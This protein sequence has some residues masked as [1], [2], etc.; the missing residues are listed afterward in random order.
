M[1]TVRMTTAQALVKFLNQQYVEFDGEQQK[2]I[3]GIFT[4]FGHGNVV[5]LGQALEEDAGELE[6]YQGRN[7]Q[8]MA[9]A[10]MAFAKQKHRKQIMACTS[11]VGP[12]SANMITSAATASANNI[13]VLLLPGDVFA[14]RQ[15]DPVLQQIEQTHD[16]SISTN[17][18][19]RAV[20]KYWDRVNRPEQLM[21]AMIQAIRVLTNPADTGAVTICLP[22]DVQGE[23]WDFPSYFFQK[24]VHR[25]ERRLPTKASLADAV[26]MIKKKKK[27]I[28]ICGGGV[29]YA[30]AA[31]ELKQFAETFR[32]P[33]GETQAGKSTIESNHPYNLGGIGVTGN[34]A[35]N[36][37]AKEAD[38]VIGIG[39]RFTD[40]TTASK[41]LFQNKEVEFLNI[42]ISE[43]HA[44]KLDA[45]KVIA[46]AKEALLALIDELQ[47]IEYQSSYTVEIADAKE[48][49]ETELARLHNI[50]FTSQD[51]KPEVEGHF[52]EDLNEY[53]DALGT[54]LT[55]TTV[56]GQINTLIDEDAIIVGAAGSLPG[57]LQRM[58]VARKPNTYHMEYGY[59]CMGYEVAGALGAKLAE[60][61][62]E[63]YAMVGDGSYQMLH[64]ELVTSLQENKK[65][66]VLLFDNSGFGCINN[67]QMGNG[68]SS[69]G[70]EFRYRN[71]ETRKLNGAIMKIDFAA[72]AAGYG[73]KTY[74]VTSIEQLREAL[75]DAKKQTVSTLIDIKVL[76]KTM[77]NGYDSWWHVGVAEVS[78][79][80]S[81]QASYESKVS[82]LQQARSY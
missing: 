77:T 64:S 75:K 24:R 41:Q 29:R 39:T 32:I 54:E 67:L 33:F 44:N 17:D 82:N 80:P 56:I 38:L 66:N 34:L 23:A 52:D 53:V 55:Q 10:A 31:E 14:T 65:I 74:R 43:F 42:N 61:S 16:L 2:F 36:T 13:P 68:M 63:V 12:G 11:S 35:A 47:V 69:F 71:Q 81:V 46:D 7:E 37:I 51:F 3:K 9:N 8:G 49:W 5:G 4:I 15:P 21:T 28:M 73:V 22:Q 25:I 70:T 18:A 45:L 40:F 79:S 58:W 78:N 6:V 76:P 62:K 26:E 27:P 60:P 1:Q 30:E 19:F 72:S 57:D 50:R 20:S 59:S 48:A